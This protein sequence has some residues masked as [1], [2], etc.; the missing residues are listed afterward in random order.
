[1]SKPMSL[2]DRMKKNYEFRAKVKLTRRIP[3]ILRLDGVAF[4][5][6]TKRMVRPFD[7]ILTYL[8]AETMKSLCE[9]IQGAT[10]AYQQSDEISIFLKD[11]NKLTSEAWFDYNL[12]KITSVSASMAARLFYEKAIAIHTFL[13]KHKVFPDDIYIPKDQIDTHRFLFEKKYI[14]EAFFDCRAFDIPKEEVTNYFIWRQQDASRNSIQ[15]AGQA[16]FSHKQLH[17]KSTSDIQEMLW[18]EK[19]INWNNFPVPNRRG[20]AVYQKKQ[21][22]RS[23]FII[24]RDIPIFTKD[25]DFIERW[26]KSEE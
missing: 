21:N 10:F 9:K 22:E 2:S 14:K 20:I 16:H 24:D 19:N 18:K 25:R 6:Y 13:K 11:Y 17:K 12:Q 7:Y 4:H 1:M 26:I 3:I 8:M 23:N 15:M 5:S